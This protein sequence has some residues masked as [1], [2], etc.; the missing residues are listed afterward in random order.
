MEK[1][2]DN[3][4]QGTGG[5][6]G[7]SNSE[8]SWDET[9]DLPD[10]MVEALRERGHEARLEGK[11]VRLHDFQLMPLLIGGI[12]PV[13]GG[14][15]TA[16]TV[17]VHHPNLCPSGVF[18]YQYARGEDTQS[19]LR[20]GFLT[21]IDLDLIALLDAVEAE[22]SRVS[23]M[24]ATFP[25][26]GDQEAVVRRA[27]FGPV[28]WYAE[29]EDSTAESCDAEGHGGFCPCCFFTKSIE[30]FEHLL[31]G[32]ETYAIRFYATRDREGL[33]IA[34][35]RINGTEFDEGKAALRRYVETWPNRGVEWRK[36]YVVVHTA[37][38]RTPGS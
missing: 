8:R 30:A 33:A 22:A 24:V 34:D 32:S 29:R 27:V 9:F 2:A 14:V 25:G 15:Q 1:L 35:C 13:D 4:G 16:T 36:Q 28:A 26:E 7:F 38:D 6:V 12:Q 5:R 11:L 3:P 21:W 17:Q 23:S 37:G 31:K 18:E 20:N 19:S 10:A